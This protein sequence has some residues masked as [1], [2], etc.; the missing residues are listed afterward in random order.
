M[1]FITGTLWSFSLLTLLLGILGINAIVAAAQSSS[2]RETSLRMA[3]GERRFRS[4]I[5]VL[6][7]GL[8]PAVIG[9]IIGAVAAVPVVG[10]F[11]NQLFLTGDG[12]KLSIAVMTG[13]ALVLSS[14][15]AGALPA[16]RAAR[17][18]MVRALRV[19]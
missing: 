15:V 9:A 6:G 4:A 19:E 12:M 18:D 13:F 7:I 1:T 16:Y 10:V 2:V 14:I 8:R 5:R 11:E 17:T 3:L